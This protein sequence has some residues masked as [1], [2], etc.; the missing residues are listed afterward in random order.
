MSH[1][2]DTPPDKVLTFL[3]GTFSCAVD[4]RAVREVTPA[5]AA[6]L[7]NAPNGHPQAIAAD[8]EA[9]LPVVDLRRRFRLRN[10]RTDRRTGA[11]RIDTPQGELLAIVDRLG[12]V[13]PIDPTRIAPPPQG[14]GAPVG[15]FLQGT[16]R[17]GDQVHLILATEALGIP[18]SD[19][20]QAP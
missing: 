14:A 10:V 15:R 7:F 16:V 12:A 19:A 3:L 11:L 1:S 4:V 8:R 20:P 2:Q 9:A 5:P 13:C 6:V 18:D 17:I